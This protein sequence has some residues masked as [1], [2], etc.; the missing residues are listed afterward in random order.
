[1]VMNVYNKYPNIKPTTSDKY[2]VC[3]ETGIMYKGKP[4]IDYGIWR[5]NA[6][7]GSWVEEFDHPRAR[8]L[9]W[10]QLEKFNEEEFE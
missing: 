4:K 6:V 7:T 2:I 3:F 1:M 10:Q 9:A 8:V 5:Y